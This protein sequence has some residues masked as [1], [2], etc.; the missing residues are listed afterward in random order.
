MSSN[1]ILLSVSLPHF[2]CPPYLE[3]LC[4]RALI[5]LRLW[6]YINHVLTYLLTDCTRFA[7]S[8]PLD[9]H[10]AAAEN[11]SAQSVMNTTRHCST[12]TFLQ[13]CRCLQ[14]SCNLLTNLPM[15]FQ[16][17]MCMGMEF[18]FPL[19]SHGNFM[20]I[21]SNTNTCMRK[22]EWEEY[23]WRW[24]WEWLLF[25]VCQNSHRS[26]QCECNQIKFIQR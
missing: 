5:F 1:D 24:E 22:W 4:P 19:E 25:H 8:Q 14:N 13:I 16:L 12:V 17:E 9:E 2:S 7:W 11:F 18:P 10:L 15:R 3:Y 21:G 23:M 26:T 20:G 6:R